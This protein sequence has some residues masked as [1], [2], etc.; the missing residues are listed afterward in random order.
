MPTTPVKTEGEIFQNLLHT[1]AAR[2]GLTNINAT[3]TTAHLMG[4]AAREIATA[5]YDMVEMARGF[6]Y[7]TATGDTLD[8]RA[9]EFLGGAIE[10]FPARFAVGQLTFSRVTVTAAPVTIPVGTRCKDPLTGVVYVTTEAGTIAAFATTSS[11]PVDARCEI[12][13]TVGN[14]GAGAVSEII[15]SVS[16]VSAV[17][18]SA[19]VFGSDRESDAELQDRLAAAVAS[20]PRCTPHALAYA[21]LG[22]ED[23]DGTGKVIRFSSVFEDPANPGYAIVYVD[24]GTGSI[25]N[26]ET[27]AGLT[28]STAVTS[29]ALVGTTVTLTATGAFP[30]TAGTL[31]GRQVVVIDAT[32][33]GNN[34]TFTIVTQPDANTITYTNAVGFSEAGGAATILVGELM[35]LGMAGP[36]SDSAVGGEEFIDLRVPPVVDGTQTI[37]V[38][39]AGGSVTARVRGTSYFLAS[40]TGR[41][42]FSPPLVAGDRVVATYVSYDGVIREAQK[43]INGDANDAS[44]Y[45]GYAAAG[46]DVRVQPP[47]HRPVIVSVTLVLA[48]GYDRATAVSAARTAISTY[49]NTLSIGEDVIRAEI[50]ERVMGVPGVVDV[51][52]AIPTGNVPVNDHSI[53][54]IASASLTVL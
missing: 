6:D 37:V 23:P 51:I 50:I 13:G 10:R 11:P 47:T 52:V 14:V 3:S 8:E 27:I 28:A 7:R 12:V 19:F 31:V 34:G 25:A 2:A 44:K 39:A 48:A 40:G 5:Y 32:T 49:V 1:V 38:Q 15:G 54:R 20:L 42:F 9:A 30:A 36:L 53:G 33:P 45:P 29:F 4:A 18:S 22:V 41:V 46:V 26:F 21:M 17:T 35:T 24:D 16:G 43:I